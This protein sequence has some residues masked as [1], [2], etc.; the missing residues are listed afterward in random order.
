MSGLILCT[1]QSEVP[2][3]IADA[4]LNIYSIEEFAYYLYNNA[5]FV[6][7]NFF[8][9]DLIKYIENELGLNKVAQKL[10][11]A[12]SQKLDFAEMVMIIINSSMYYSEQAVKKFE[13]ELRIIGSK[14]M[15]ERMKA[16]AEMLIENGKFMSAKKTLQNIL[17]NSTYKKPGNDFY[18]EVYAELGKIDCRMFYFQDGIEKYKKAFALDTKEKFF[19]NI[20][21]AKLM[22]AFAG[23]EKADLSKEEMINPELTAKCREEFEMAMN[24][25]KTSE[26]YEK[27]SKVFVYD[28]RHNLDDYY[29]GILGVLDSWKGDYRS[30]M[31]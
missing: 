13:K 16:R 18:A 2:Y 28:G 4:D 29:E 17:S 9:E 6:D 3:R 7:E 1:K 10:K 8:D 27:L 20:V 5:Y 23:D 30:D 15:L 19:V 25:V 11:Y 31:S 26:E 21:N 24:V 14:G 22:Q 12:I